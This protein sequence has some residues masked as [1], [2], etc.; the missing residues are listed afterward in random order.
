MIAEHVII[1]PVITE[2]VIVSPVIFDTLMTEA[3]TVEQEIIINSVTNRAHFFTNQPL[4]T[5]FKLI[6]EQRTN[7]KESMMKDLEH[8]LRLLYNDREVAKK[9]AI[10]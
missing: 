7:T 9:Y 2:P 5:E 3:E 10:C 4:N 6:S 8:V 1:D